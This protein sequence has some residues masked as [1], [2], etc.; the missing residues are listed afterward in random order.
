[1][2]RLIGGYF[3]SANV[4]VAGRGRNAAT[5]SQQRHSGWSISAGARFTPFIHFNSLADL[6]SNQKINKEIRGLTLGV[7]LNVNSGD[8]VTPRQYAKSHTMPTFT[9]N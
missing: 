9:T 2:L 3:T 6:C 8:K 5:M 4:N 7:I 1:M